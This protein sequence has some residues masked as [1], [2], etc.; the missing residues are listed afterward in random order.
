MIREAWVSIL[1]L[2]H[3]DNTVL[4]GLK[5]PEGLK[6]ETVINNILMECAELEILF[7]DADFMKEAVRQWSD[8]CLPVWQHLYDTTQYEYNPIWN[9]DGTFRELETRDLAGQTVNDVKG[10]NSGDWSDSD[11]QDS[12]DTGTILRERTE[13]G[14]IGVTTTQQ[15]IKE[16]REI[17]DFNV[18]ARIVDDFKMRFCLLL[19]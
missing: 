15:M 5:V 4:D 11:K 10:Y 2:Y 1:G 6:R 16:E 17:A 19:Y 18:I 9:K 3:H 12:T 7:P 8:M 14:N 13:Q